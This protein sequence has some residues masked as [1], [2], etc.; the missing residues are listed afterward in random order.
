MKSMDYDK[1]SLEVLAILERINRPKPWLAK[2]MGISYQAFM[3]KLRGLHGGFKQGEMLLI[4]KI[5]ENEREMSD[6]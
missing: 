6:L 1:N 4:N 2:Q 3:Y 5:E